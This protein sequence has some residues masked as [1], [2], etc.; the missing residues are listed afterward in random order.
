MPNKGV[1]ELAKFHTWMESD[2]IAR[3]EVKQDVE[4]FLND[5]K[6]NT[7]IV[8][9]FFNG[10]KFPLLVDIRNIKSISPEAQEHFTIKERKSV[11]CAYAMVV[12]SSSSRMIGNFF[13]TFRKP[14]VPVKLFN[15]EDKALEWLRTFIA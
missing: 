6:E 11:V 12:A 3:T 4:I 8:E 7:V 13:L 1:P 10:K 5:A 9:T 14:S 15:E 2:G